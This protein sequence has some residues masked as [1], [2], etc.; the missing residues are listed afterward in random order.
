MLSKIFPHF[1]GIMAQFALGVGELLRP[2]VCHIFAG[3]ILISLQLVGV[4]LIPSNYFIGT[5]KSP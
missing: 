2:I 3:S 5:L 4:L 1:Y